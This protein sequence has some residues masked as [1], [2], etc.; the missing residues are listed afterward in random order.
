MNVM[1]V[2]WLTANEQRAW[3]AYLRT[4]TLL[5]ARLN[6]QLQ[7]D[8]GLSLPEYE[9]L[10]RLSEA[11]A[12][13]LRPFQLGLTLDWEQSRLS[14]LLSRMARRGFVARQDCPGDRRGA[15]I[16]LTGPGRAAIESAAPGHVAAVRRLV[17]DQL[18][19]AQ[20]AVFGQAFEAILAA[21]EN[22]NQQLS[23]AGQQFVR[24][25]RIVVSVSLMVWLSSRTSAL[26][27]RAG[28]PLSRPVSLIDPT[29]PICAEDPAVAEDP[30]N[31]SCPYSPLKPN[32]PR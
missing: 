12:G 15:E 29:H 28:P 11:P 6:R 24:N 32:P 2:H 23:R 14:H 8:S 27:C 18:D 3:R 30:V 7:A 25:A 1:A 5:T 4:G 21:L 26:F 10:V 13:K 20:A 31:D 19:S 17:F 9:V 16:V 22:A